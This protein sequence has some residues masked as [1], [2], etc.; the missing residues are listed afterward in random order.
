MQTTKTLITIASI[1]FL[2]VSCRSK[3]ICNEIK[4]ATI[5][6]LPLCDISFQFN[7]CRC[8]C[9]NINTYTTVEPEACGDDFEAGDYPIT[10]CESLSGFFV[11][12]WAVEIRPKIRRLDRIKGDYCR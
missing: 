4:A 2:S 9:F 5:K 6:N 1:L 3:L 10:Y 11:E 7:R 8:R 12:D